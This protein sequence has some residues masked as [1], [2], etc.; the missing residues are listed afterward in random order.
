MVSVPVR[1]RVNDVMGRLA[2]LGAVRLAEAL[3]VMAAAEDNS[4][5]SAVEVPVRLV[6]ESSLIDTAPAELKVS[7]PK[8]MVSVPVSP[9]VIDR[10]EERRLGVK[11]RRGEA[12]SVMEEVEGE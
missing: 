12:R 3:S 9:R 11:A 5:L 2:L 4:R 7:V 6:A 8:F 10:S 1:T